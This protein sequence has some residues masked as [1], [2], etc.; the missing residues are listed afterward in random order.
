MRKCVFLQRRI[1][2]NEHGLSYRL[3]SKHVDSLI[4]VLSLHEASAVPTPSHVTSGKRHPNT[5]YIQL[6]VQY[7]QRHVCFIQSVPAVS[8]HNTL[9]QLNEEE[10]AVYMSSTI[11][12]YNAPYKMDVV[13][14]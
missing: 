3:D 13:F 4:T 8:S 2:K 10:K 1:R 12:Q 11:M 9:K 14:S 7:S 5:P 6:H